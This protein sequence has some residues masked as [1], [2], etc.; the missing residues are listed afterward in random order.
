MNRNGLTDMILD[1]KKAMAF[2][3]GVETMCFNCT[4][5]SD[6]NKA[7]SAY[8]PIPPEYLTMHNECPDWEFDDVPF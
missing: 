1:I 8:G 4:K 2:Y 5:F 7:C 6:A 3:E